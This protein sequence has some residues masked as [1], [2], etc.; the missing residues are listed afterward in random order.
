MC[1]VLHDTG[2]LS[3]AK[4]K[5]GRRNAAIIST[6]TRSVSPPSSI[7]RSTVL[8][9]RPIE[10]RRTYHPLGEVRPAR[11]LSGH[12]VSPVRVK[13][14]PKGKPMKSALLSHRIQFVDAKRVLICVRRKVRRAVLIARGAGGSRKKKHRNYYSGVSC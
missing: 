5:S 14:G 8:N 12:A 10:D 2:L 4:S 9:L 1:T 11:K 3:M 6:A 7:R 13:R